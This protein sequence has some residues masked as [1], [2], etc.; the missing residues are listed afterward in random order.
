MQYLVS[1]T[2]T[3]VLVADLGV[4]LAHPTVDRDLALEFTPEEIAESADL[5]AYISSGTLTLKLETNEYG[6]YDVDPVEYKSYALLQQNLPPERT[7][8]VITETELASRF[9]TTPIY[10]GVFPVNISSTT[11]VTNV[12]VANTAKF[13]DW[14][15]SPGDNI[16]ISG[17]GPN[18][19]YKTVNYVI[20]QNMFV[21]NEAL[22]T[23]LNSGILFAL[24]PAGSTKIGVDN[25]S[26][27]TISGNTLQEVLDSI[28]D[29]MTGGGI[30]ATQHKT[31]R[32]LIHLADIG[33]PYEGFASGAYRETLPA[34]DPFPTSI[35]WWES[36][37]KLKKIVEKN[38]SY[39]SGKSTPTPITYKVYDTD[40]STI[41][42]TVTDNI[43]YSGI[44]E[45]SRT[46][47][48]T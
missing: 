8:G 38:I 40:G 19:G 11:A 10:D 37:S 18:D 47:T 25:R 43:A 46:R 9:S 41:L 30:T 12:I 17:N 21:T 6:L 39:A 34:N 24:N 31:L 29:N 32:Q 45:L 3:D 35:I 1:T 16:F 33:G 28:D 44:N 14:L 23:T 7:E 4:F 42:A 13:Q 26:F 27:T 2:G 5:T 20:A 15:L 36:S 48:I 22:T